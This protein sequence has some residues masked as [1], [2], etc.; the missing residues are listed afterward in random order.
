MKR[1]IR[2]RQAVKTATGLMLLGIGVAASG[3]ST[4]YVAT[5]GT[6]VSPFNSWATAATNIQ[7]AVDVASSGDTVEVGNGLYIVTQRVTIAKGITVR[8]SY[9]YSNVEVNGNSSAGC[10]AVG[11]ANAVLEGFTVKAGSSNRGGGISI[12]NGLIHNCVITGNFATLF[13]GG[14]DI[15]DGG[16]VSNCAVSG[17][18]API[19]GGGSGGGV[20]CSG[21]GKLVNSTVSGNEAAAGGG[22]YTFA[23][24]V[25]SECVIISNR[26]WDSLGGSGSGGGIQCN[27]TNITI[28]NCRI[29]HNTAQQLGGGV[30]LTGH[31][32]QKIIGCLI[33]DNRTANYGGG[34]YVNLAPSAYA[35]E[36][37]TIAE[38]RATNLWWG[39]GGGIC[40]GS[41]QAISLKNCIVFSNIATVAG[42]NYYGVDSGPISGQHT[43][44]TPSLPGISN[45]TAEPMFYRS[46][47]FELA[48]GSPCIDTGTN[49]SWMTTALDLDAKTR[50]INSIVDM[51]AYE[52]GVAPGATSIVLRILSPYPNQTF[53]APATVNGDMR[54]EQWDGPGIT[55]TVVS[56]N[57]LVVDQRIWTNAQYCMIFFAWSNVVSSDYTMTLQAWDLQ[58]MTLSTSV[59]F[60]VHGAPSIVTQPVSLMCFVGQSAA[61]SVAATGMPSTLYYQWRKDGNAI[62]AATGSSHTIA[63][64]V[65]NDTGG[66]DCVVSNEIGA[67]T[68]ATATLTVS[69][70]DESSFLAADLDGDRKDDPIVVNEG[71][72]WVR[73]S[74]SQFSRWDG[75]Y[76]GSDP[77][78]IPLAADFYGDRKADPAV[79][80]AGNKWYVW[81]SENDYQRSGPFMGGDISGWPLAPDFYGDGK[82]DPTVVIPDGNLWYVWLSPSYARS[83]PFMGGD[84]IGIPLAD[85]FYGDGKADPTVVVNGNWYVWFSES[86]YVM[87]GPFVG[88]GADTTPVLGDFDGDGRA[89][90]AA[91]DENG[92]WYFWVS[93]LN[94]TRVGP[95]FV[96]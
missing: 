79:V 41:G 8:G 89:D 23:G 54:A 2:N 87:A 40:G 60:T 73:F 63:S 39:M 32:V 4:L 38:N 84:L 19:T 93:G 27:G 55:Q 68:S 70:A 11:H 35:I 61:F 34:I 66:Y 52:Y 88:S 12:T 13:G 90:P 7:S 75:P 80:M 56:A 31:T 29:M 21:N 82:A 94:Y 3:A 96:Q 91:V 86:N 37:C 95:L 92:G 51:G 6:H 81:L 65:T 45:I 18:S 28:Q 1:F 50:I 25:V 57:G 30:Y 16:T 62:G 42:S 26:A 74:A 5:N 48:A 77:D 83:G 71:R 85:D 43:C 44:T 36:S 14:V 53:T 33:Y 67:V 58:G 64:V 17:N 46:G 24:S 22:V 78:G 49:Q 47:S 10:F 15:Y 59:F 69:S 76:I 9:G 20:C 72:W